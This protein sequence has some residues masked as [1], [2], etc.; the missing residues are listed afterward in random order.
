MKAKYL[1]DVNLPYR[2]SHWHSKEFIF[3]RNINSQMP[4]RGIWE[5]AREKNLTIVTKDADFAHRIINHIPPPKVIHFR[6]G[7]M[8]MSDFHDFIAIHWKE[9]TVFNQGHKLVN[10]YNDRIEGVR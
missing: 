3:Q 9:I 5:Y 2:F 1:V 7:N 10:V 4:D 8:R 6:T